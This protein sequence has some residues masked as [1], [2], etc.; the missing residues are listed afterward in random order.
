MKL[1]DRYKFTNGIMGH[2]PIL[3][4][5][6]VEGDLWRDEQTLKVGQVRDEANGDITF[7]FNDEN[8]NPDCVRRARHHVRFIVSG[9]PQSVF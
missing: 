4:L 7:V 6:H 1:L 8:G 5:R 3:Q 2:D 9:L